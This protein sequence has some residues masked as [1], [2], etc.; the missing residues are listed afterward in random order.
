M[1]LFNALFW[2][3]DTIVSMFQG[4]DHIA[5][6]VVRWLKKV[7]SN[8]GSMLVG[9]IFS[10]NSRVCEYG[11]DK[12]AHDIGFGAELRRA[13]GML[14]KLDGGGDMTLMDRIYASHPDTENR[15]AQLESLEDIEEDEGL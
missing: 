6:R 7:I 9:A 4:R 15:I 12:F 1:A 14:Q 10:L 2:V 13:L 11:A 5:L 8:L 3:A